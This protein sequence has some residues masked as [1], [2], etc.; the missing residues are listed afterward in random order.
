MSKQTNSIAITRQNQLIKK[1]L[2]FL[3]YPELKNLDGINSTIQQYFY[4]H[5]NRLSTSF[6]LDSASSDSENISLS[7]SFQY[8]SSDSENNSPQIPTRNLGAVPINLKVKIPTGVDSPPSVSPTNNL[9]RLQSEKFILHE[10]LTEVY[11][12][13][14]NTDALELYKIVSHIFYKERSSISDNVLKC[15]DVKGNLIEEYLKDAPVQVPILDSKIP[16]EK[17]PKIYI[18]KP[19]EGHTHFH[20]M[21]DDEYQVLSSRHSIHK[22]LLGNKETKITLTGEELVEES[23]LARARRYEFEDRIL[24]Q[25]LLAHYISSELDS[26]TNIT[27]ILEKIAECKLDTATLFFLKILTSI[28]SAKFVQ[29]VI[30]G[31][32]DTQNNIYIQFFDI[33]LSDSSTTIFVASKE[34]KIL[35]Y[36]HILSSMNP[37][38][39]QEHTPKSI[40]NIKDFIQKNLTSNFLQKYAHEIITT[41]YFTSELENAITNKENVEEEATRLLKNNPQYFLPYKEDKTIQEIM[42]DIVNAINEVGCARRS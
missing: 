7:F 40:S 32:Q 18:R 39:F 23:N 13:I 12:N 24:A 15:L 17:S 4:A 6:S 21:I 1:A 25:H 9:Q 31:S 38:I 29:N 37:E 30:L 11:K 5:P 41:G 16:Q 42:D 8:G 35:W 19:E 2:L 14:Q 20:F 27:K 26:N 3:Q 33:L 28:I 10:I 34:Q 36:M 22:R